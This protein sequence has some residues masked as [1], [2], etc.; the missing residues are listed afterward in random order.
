MNTRNDLSDKPNPYFRSFVCA[1]VIGTY[2]VC[3]STMVDTPHE[4]WPA[5]RTAIGYLVAGVVVA[6]GA[7]KS[8]KISHWW[9]FVLAIILIQLVIAC[10][11]EFGKRYLFA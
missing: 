3:Y 7:S 5:I 10:A 8:K 11:L 2:S 9:Q 1:F 4:A 6:V